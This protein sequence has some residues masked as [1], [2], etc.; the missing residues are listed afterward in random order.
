[1]TS[2]LDQA[3]EAVFF[4]SCCLVALVVIW[5]AAGEVGLSP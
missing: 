1:M 3:T 5:T 4:F 2:R